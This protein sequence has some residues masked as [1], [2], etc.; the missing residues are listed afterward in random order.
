MLAFV[1]VAT[2]VLPRFADVAHAAIMRLL[3]FCAVVLF[4]VVLDDRQSRRSAHR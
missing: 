2:F 3:T 1:A 4:A